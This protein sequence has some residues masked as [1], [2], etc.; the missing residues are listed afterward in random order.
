MN[1]KIH[2]RYLVVIVCKRLGKKNYVGNDILKIQPCNQIQVDK[3]NL[4]IE[5]ETLK[6]LQAIIEYKIS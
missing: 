3:K 4:Y 5:I 2:T 1:F 6:D